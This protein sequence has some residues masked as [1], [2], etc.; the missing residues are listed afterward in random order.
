MRSTAVAQPFFAKCWGPSKFT[1]DI[2]AKLSKVGPSLQNRKIIFIY[3]DLVLNVLLLMCSNQKFVLQLTL[4]FWLFIAKK[5]TPFVNKDWFFSCHNY[6]FFSS[7]DIEK[8]NNMA[9]VGWHSFAKSF[10]NPGIFHFSHS[11]GPKDSKKS[12]FSHVDGRLLCQQAIQI[13]EVDRSK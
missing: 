12:K 8:G 5:G 11:L 3:W 4:P 13:Y 9:K 1:T 7:F 2:E 10:Q 6:F